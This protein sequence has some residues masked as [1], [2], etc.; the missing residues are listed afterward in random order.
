M[1]SFMN[2]S[3]TARLRSP[4]YSFVIL[5]WEMHFTFSNFW[6]KCEPPKSF[7]FSFLLVGDVTTP[8][9]GQGN[10]NSFLFTFEMNLFWNVGYNIPPSVTFMLE[11]NQEVREKLFQNSSCDVWWN[12]DRL[13]VHD[14]LLQPV[15]LGG[16]MLHHLPIV[17]VQLL[18]A[19]AALRPKLG[20][21][22][23]VQNDR[24]PISYDFHLCRLG[25][26]PGGGSWQNHSLQWAE[27]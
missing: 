22:V 5:F 2:S 8:T 25:F 27:A 18:L 23:Q 4:A 10:R 20:Q 21:S 1:T 12:R 24:S 6:M 7:N 19:Q 3:L 11:K 16:V 9:P 14:R 17:P 15:V 13:G 26:S